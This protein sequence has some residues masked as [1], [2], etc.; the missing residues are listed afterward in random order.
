MT[1][2]D[3]NTTPFDEEINRRDVPALKVHTLVLGENSEHSFAAGLSLF[4][5]IRALTLGFYY[6][7]I[8][9]KDREL[10]HPPTFE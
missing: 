4:M 6:P 9:K 2:S 8:V 1:H 5:I 7:R 3:L 10:S